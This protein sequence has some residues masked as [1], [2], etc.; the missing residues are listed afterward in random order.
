MYFLSSIQNE[1]SFYQIGLILKY[2][3]NIVFTIIPIIVTIT[4]MM[5]LFKYMLKPDSPG[6]TIKIITNRIL[7]GLI[8]FLLPT[9]ISSVFTLIDDYDDST[10]TKYYN[11]ASIDKIEQL[12]K[13]YENEQKANANKTKAKLKEAA[14]KREEEERKRNEQIEALRKENENNNE[15]EGNY[16]GDSTSSGEYGSVTVKNGVFYLP[17]KRA[18]KDSDIPKQPGSYGLNPIFW[19]RL[20]AL[21]NDAKAKGYNISVTS[22]WRSYSS[23]RSLWDSST[24]ACNVRGNWVACPG[25]S[26]H[27][28]GIA[29]DLSFNGTS[30]SGSWDCN[31]ETKWANANAANYGLKFRMSWEPWHIE[32]AQVQGGSFG[33]CTASC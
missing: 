17:N 32:P 14:L 2:A 12:K 29:A 21:I 20:S 22:G 33:S 7:A 30:C 13:E 3:V 26:R 5:D 28:F 11:E 15:S 27:G 31:N 8:I 4:A 6:P 25:G 18:T 23:Q 16:S 10:I 1:M 9:L 19:E 24:R